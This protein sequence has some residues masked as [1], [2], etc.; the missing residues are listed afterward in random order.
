MSSKGRKPADPH[1]F[2]PTP[3]FAIDA[4]LTSDLL[5]LP[6]GRWLEPCAG[7]GSLIKA[8]RNI[9][10][11]IR[12]TVYELQSK[13]EPFLEPLMTPLDTLIPASD[14]LASPNDQPHADVCIAN[15]PFTLAMKFVEVALQRA[16]WVVILQRKGWFGPGPRAEWLRQHC[17]DDYTLPKRPSFR[18][19][20]KTDSADYSWYVWPP[21]DRRR[22]TGQIALL[23]RPASLQA[24]IKLPKAKRA[25]RKAKT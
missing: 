22:R 3:S 17:P 9:R 15:P 13:F 7:T 23:E 20:K 21:G 1:E 8:I 16:D 10:D 14:F 12:W 6:G 4:L 11:D 18:P 19:D 25:P 2:F 5:T 24:V